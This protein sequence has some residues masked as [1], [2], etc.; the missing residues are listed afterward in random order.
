MIKH[1]FR[2]RQLRIKKQQ[3]MKVYKKVKNIYLKEKIERKIVFIYFHLNER[4]FYC[5]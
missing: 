2:I 5:N 3:K 1:R 4:K